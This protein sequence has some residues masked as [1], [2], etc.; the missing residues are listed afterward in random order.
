MCGVARP[1]RKDLLGLAAA[2]VIAVLALVALLGGIIYLFTIP[3]IDFV[4]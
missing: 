2:L 1:A 4:Q 3:L